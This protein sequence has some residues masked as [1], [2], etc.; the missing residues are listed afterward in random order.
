MLF[1]KLK[2]YQT[3]VLISGYGEFIS[4]SASSISIKINDKVNSI[5]INAME[6][7]LTHSGIRQL[8]HAL[9]SKQVTT[10]MCL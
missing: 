8:R 2:D 10:Y 3:R 6:S 5:E 4:T 1:L 7:S 9:V